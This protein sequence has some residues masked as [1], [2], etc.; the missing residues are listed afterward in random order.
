MLKSDKITEK[1]GK[2]VDST[3]NKQ[4]NSKLAKNFVTD[5]RMKNEN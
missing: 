2:N 5:T 1:N 3:N 4:R